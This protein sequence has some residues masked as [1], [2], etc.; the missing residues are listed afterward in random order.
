MNG[1]SL[2]QITAP[3][4]NP[5]DSATVKL[6]LR[7]IGTTEDTLID[8]YTLAAVSALDGPD[9]LIGRALMT[10][11]WDFALDSFPSTEIKIPLPPLQS[12][13]SIKY[14]DTS[15]VE[16]TL[17][18]ARYY[19]D[20]ASMP[21]WVVVDADGWPETYD[22]ANAVTIRFVAGYASAA[23]V[24]AALRAALL[25]HIGDLFENRQNSTERQLFDNKAYDNL[26]FPFRIL[27]I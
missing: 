26:T 22:S 12:V 19:V 10:Q 27:A 3:S 20:T 4:T 13:T 6:H 18:S 15:G 5:V 24:P 7:V 1:M 8:L 11:T 9:G 23:L 14:L 17:S 21:G 2:K 16:Q 25:L